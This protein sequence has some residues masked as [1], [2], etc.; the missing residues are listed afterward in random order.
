MI[1]LQSIDDFDSLA[2][3]DPVTG[4]IRWSSRGSAIVKGP[5]PVSGHITKLAGHLLCFYRLDGA[6]HFRS[7]DQDIELRGS[8]ST[9]QH[10]CDSACTFAVRCNGQTLLSLAY[11]RPTIAPS[12]RAGTVYDADEEAYDFCLF[13][14]NIMSD[15]KR[16]A[17]IYTDCF[18]HQSVV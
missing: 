15:P 7:D 6:L 13:V 10:C 18:R 2:G 5:P 14:H 12:Y 1:V 9:D 3:L 17:R 8:Y 11:E 4:S 16:R